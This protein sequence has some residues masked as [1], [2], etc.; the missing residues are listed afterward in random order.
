MGNSLSTELS[1]KEKLANKFAFLKDIHCL[2]YFVLLLIGVGLGFFGYAL[3]TQRFTTPYSGDFAQQAYQAYY[4]FYDDWW[5]FFRTGKFPFFDTNT[6]LGADNVAANTYYGL[7]SPFTLPILF[8][9]RNFIP[10]MM[11]I[12]S[13]ARLV[14]G[15]LLFRVYLKYLGASERSARL[16]A[17]AY[18][19]TGWMAYYLWFNPFYEVMTFFPLIMFG[20]EKVIKERKIWAVTLGFFLLGI[21]NYFFLLTAGVFGVIYAGF[22]YFQ[23]LKQRNVKENLLVILYGFL[24]FLFGFGMTMFCVLPAVLS[25]FSINRAT[26]S[27]Y[28]PTL[29]EAFKSGNLQQAF[30]IIFTCWR[31]DVVT[32]TDYNAYKFSFAFPLAEYFFPPIS[33]RF[34][35]VM[36]Y[37]YFENTGS[38]IFIY[39][40][41]MILFGCSIFRSFKNKKISHFIAI[42]LGTACLFIP[43]LYF[44][45]GAFVTAYGRWEIVIP[46][47]IY[48][49]LALNYDHLDEIKRPVVI[50]SGALTCACMIG[51]IFLAK[52]VISTY[53]NF[54]DFG[55]VVYMIIYEVV[56]CAAETALFAG[57][58]KKK[59]LHLSIKLT[60]IGEI[61]VVGT[62]VANIHCLQ[63][64]DTSVG[65]GMPYVEM[66]SALVQ[67]IN[68]I[69]NSYFRVHNSRAYDGNFNVQMLENY[70][71][72]ACFHSFYNND[73]DDFLR[74]SQIMMQDYSWTG[75]DF[76]KRAN[77]DEFLGVKYYIS[78][79]SEMT[80]YYPDANG[81]MQPVVFNF[82]V[83]LNYEKIDSGVEGYS[84]YRNTQ[85]IELGTSYDTIYYKRNCSE[86][87]GNA[88]Y[89]GGSAEALIRNEEAYFK[90]AILNDA[91]VYDIHDTY[92]DI[93]SYEE[94]PS[95]YSM[96]AIKVNYETEGVYRNKDNNYFDP[97][98]PYRDINEECRIADPNNPGDPINRIQISFKPTGSEYFPLGA[99]GSY[100]MFDYPIRGWSR[101]YNAT[102]YLIGED[103]LGNPKVITFDNTRNG[104]R[105]N[106]KCVRALYS[107][108]KV[109]RIIVCV[110]GNAFYWRATSPYS[111]EQ[112]IKLY[113][114]P[115][116]NVSARFQKAIDNGL[117]NVT[118]DVNRYTFSTNYSSNRFVITQLAH[119]K[120]WKVVGT[121]SNGVKHNL[122]TY[123]AQGGFVGFVALKGNA[124]YEMTYATPNFNK[125]LLISVCSFIGAVGLS[126]VTAVIQN[127]KKKEI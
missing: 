19:F 118:Y 50:V 101:D 4:D 29:I 100:Y 39:T 89:P 114:E 27:K 96:D 3:F 62:L 69:D 126:V 121:D 16:F 32:G 75:G 9:P 28:L 81:N 61:I 45:C 108:E 13:I 52:A 86:G 107:K 84:L 109:K 11:A 104:Y 20:I 92:G 63:D 110:D 88:F 87:I 116:E 124:T 24:G 49:Y 58:W 46:I 60:L 10:Q 115:F 90:G 68:E 91:D 14:V 98:D 44:L 122:K 67:R 2:F 51:T 30:K 105:D 6:F 106:S 5:T 47:M 25:S 127:K 56:L 36:H 82:N 94:A 55:E 40:P 99:E 102:V 34:V 97:L 125:G 76:F 113:Y 26:E 31:G 22:R 72:L 12:V 53:E 66:E 83:P 79:D 21:S 117:Q 65:G 33:N 71:G 37:Q 1:F 73:V 48:A 120:G 57:L 64:I 43:F 35:N 59:S 41:C 103:G 95:I 78:K 18:A 54:L 80:F 85:Q 74:F 7:F 77:L 119:T 70:N 123:N 111:P 8:V 93:F 23:T 42:I 17:I 15:G 112:L 38:S